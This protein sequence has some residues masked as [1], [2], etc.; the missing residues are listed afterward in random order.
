M[1]QAQSTLVMLEGSAAETEVAIA[2]LSADIVK[3]RDTFISDNATKLSETERSADEI[4]QRL[5]KANVR[6][7]Q[8][9]LTAPIAGIVQSLTVINLNQVV[10]AGQELMR[11][12]PEELPLEIEAYVLNRDIGFVRAGQPAII[13]VDSFPFTRYGTIDG[14]VTKV[15]ADA[16]P[17]S[18]A[19]HNQITPGPSTTHPPAGGPSGSA[20]TT[21]A[22]K[23]EDLVYQVIIEPATTMMIDG[24]PIPLTAGMSVSAEIKT[25]KRRVIDYVL[26]PLLEVT[27]TAMRER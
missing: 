2:V 21:A 27:S 12:V 7:G 1:A 23:A 17:G 4:A 13:K 14:V 10:G 20:V 22:Q 3:T 6:V 24:Q 26:S 15:A 25:E 19:A 11:I 18:E 5:A 9:T 16:I 8:K